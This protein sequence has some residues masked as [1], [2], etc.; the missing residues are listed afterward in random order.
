MNKVKALDPTLLNFFWDLSSED[1]NARISATSTLMSYLAEKQKEFEGNQDQEADTTFGKC[2]PQLHYTLIRL[3][4][5]IGSSRGSSRQGFAV[6]LLSVTCSSF[7]QLDL[8]TLFNHRH[9]RYLRDGRKRASRM[10]KDHC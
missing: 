10:G 4:R 7:L 3:I 6:A 1:E 2:S 8:A 5:G 9:K